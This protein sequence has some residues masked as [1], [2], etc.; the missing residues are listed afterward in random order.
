MTYVYLL[1]SPRT[2]QIYIGFTEDLKRRYGEHQKMQKHK[3]WRLI[4]Y[5]AYLR[6]ED[7][8]TRERMLKHY[9]N[10]KQGLLKRLRN[11]LKDC[12][13]FEGVE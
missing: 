7:A 13:Q 2:K 5:E 12:E 4:Y 6:R 8:V 1:Q 11:S 9:G 3:G 10:A